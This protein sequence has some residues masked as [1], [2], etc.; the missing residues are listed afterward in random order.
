LCP[1]MDS[2]WVKTREDWW[3][4]IPTTIHSPAESIG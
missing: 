3:G 4:H 2:M 1:R